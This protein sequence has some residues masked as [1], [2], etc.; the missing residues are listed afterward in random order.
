VSAVKIKEDA[1]FKDLFSLQNRVA[2]VTGGSRGI[3][4]MIAEGFLNP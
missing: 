2:P 3:G 4:K 1:M